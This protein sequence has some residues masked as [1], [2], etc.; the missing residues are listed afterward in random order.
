MPIQVLPIQVMPIQVMPIQVLAL[1]LHL[2]AYVL[3]PATFHSRGS[4]KPAIIAEVACGVAQADRPNHFLCQYIASAL[5]HGISPVVLGWNEDSWN[6]VSRKP[7]SYHLA[8]KL[9]LVSSEQKVTSGGHLVGSKE[10]V[11]AGR[12]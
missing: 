9:M 8:A 7:W 3:A 1:S 2:E 12:L 6:E 4:Q 11:G 10:L 5:M